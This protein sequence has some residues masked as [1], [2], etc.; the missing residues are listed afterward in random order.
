[1]IA[2]NWPLGAR[3]GTKGRPMRWVICALAVMALM[4]RALAGDFDILRGSEPLGSPSYSGT[5]AASISAASPATPAAAPISPTRQVRSSPTVLRNTTVE[6]TYDV[7]GWPVLG[8]QDALQL[9]VRRLRRLQLAMAKPGARCRGELHQHELVRHRL[10]LPIGRGDRPTAPRPIHVSV[11]GT[12]PINLH[13][14][15]SLRG[16][17]RT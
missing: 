14:Y 12:R 17:R 10:G 1:M 15:T 4:P 7:S 16:A 11:T 3:Q 5:G 6:Q 2:R 13:D 8:K 9:R